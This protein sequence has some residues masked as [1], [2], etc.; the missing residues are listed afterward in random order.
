M[1]GASGFVGSTLVQRCYEQDDS[2]WKAFYRS[3]G[4]ALSLARHGIP[5]H[6]V[7][8]LSKSDLSAALRGCTHVVNCT[9]GSG[10]AMKQGLRN[11][12]ECCRSQGMQRFVHLSSVA[13]Y[14]G[15][16]DGESISETH[17]GRAPKGT[18]GAIKQQQDQMV[19]AACRRGLPSVVLCPPNIS[20]AWSPF[21]IDLV[22]SMQE[23]R[24]AL[25]GGGDAP[26][27][28]IDVEN[29]VY[30]IQLALDCEQ[31]DGQRIFVTDRATPTWRELA[32]S[33]RSLASDARPIPAIS[34]A[35]AHSL[36]SNPPRQKL[37]LLRMAKHL[38]SSEVRE[39]LRADPLLASAESL[40]KDFAARVPGS[41]LARLERSSDGRGRNPGTE[42]RYAVKPIQR[43]LRSVRYSIDRATQ[44]L[45]YE[46]PV[47]MA[48]S[49]EAF[50]R[51]YRAVFGFDSGYADLL[52]R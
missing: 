11:I 16:F 30:A 28:L 46:P 33:L 3:S 41:W 47:S 14:A 40:A 25:V 27:S 1:L 43:Q 31:A 7:D 23:E 8:I 35:D 5:L 10:Q 48:Q 18:Y 29:L 39:T 49:Q 15:P 21:M 38:A 6:Q 26:C 34:L 36:L 13:V 44:V 37:S 2:E 51:W 22:Q 19:A 50:R 24:L 45:D 20:G 42:S 52:T 12:L 9:R 4:N 32:E 17:P